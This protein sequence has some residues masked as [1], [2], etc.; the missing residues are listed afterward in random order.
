MTEGKVVHDY[1]HGQIRR[2][3]DKDPALFL[4]PYPNENHYK[5]RNR[6]C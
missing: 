2:E 4:N 3:P 5:D 6:A 1:N